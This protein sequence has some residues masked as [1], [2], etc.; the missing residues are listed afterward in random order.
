M[1]ALWRLAVSP[2]TFAVLCL[3]W[4][5]DLGLG[6]LVAYRR[7]DLF[8]SMD[9]YPFALW[10]REVGRGALPWS[11]WVHLLAAL[12]WLMTASLLLCTVNW[13]WKR[14]R[15]L[16]GAGEVLVH[17]GFLLV[18]AGYVAGAV[19]GERVHG[20]VV[21][22]GAETAVPGMGLRLALREL[23]FRRNAAGETLD[24]VSALTLRD[25]A[26]REVS[27][28]ARL[29]HPLISGATVVYPR[30]SKDVLTGVLLDTP[31]GV[32]E[33]SPGRPQRLPD[34]SF[35]ALRALTQPDEERGGV[36]GPAVTVGLLE[37]TG[38][39]LGEATLA[40]ARGAVFAT[41]A[42]VPIGVR[43]LRGFSLGR[44]DVHRDPGVRLVLAG[45]ALLLAGTL[46]A[47]A[48]YLASRP[49]AAA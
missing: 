23:S 47:L 42:G 9:A 46:W 22:P 12:T 26:G 44:Y 3:L 49:G 2:A 1:R 21:A 24:T 16:R 7:A 33:L 11:A 29:N 34:G 40:P 32:V 8:G 13:F 38:R 20:V 36:P 31:G 37:A 14:R 43:D 39:L 5:L 28:T 48:V 15:R 35:L 18:F 30:G 25:A 45:A 10:L 19:L 27:G 17:L 4:C 6:S 41:V